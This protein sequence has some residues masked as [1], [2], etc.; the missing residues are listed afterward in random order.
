LRL[1]STN[2]W[3]LMRVFSLQGPGAYQIAFAPDGKT[4]AVG[5]AFKILLMTLAD[6][7]LARE[8]PVPAKGV[9]GLAYS[10]NG[11]WLALAAADK[12]VRVWAM[13]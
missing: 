10:P 9:Y 12:K 13:G 4:I 1:W 11:R 5:M 6:G 8:L 7:K 2:D 3:K